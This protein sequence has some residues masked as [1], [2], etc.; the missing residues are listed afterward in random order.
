M[1][2]LSTVT[3]PMVA[4][5]GPR[6]KAWLRAQLYL[7]PVVFQ[8]RSG[9]LMIT[10]TKKS[11]AGKYICVGTN[12]VGERESEIAELTVLGNTCAF[13]ILCHHIL[14]FT[15]D[16]SDCQSN[17]SIVLI[18]VGRTQCD[19][20]VVFF[21]GMKVQC[22]IDCIDYP[23]LQYARFLEKVY[24]LNI[25]QHFPMPPFNNLFATHQ[26]PAY[27]PSPNSF[28]LNSTLITIMDDLG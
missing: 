7:I 8:I 10:N 3:L 4:P 24:Q 28:H 20:L 13:F 25:F 27:F 1:I 6:H 17:Y 21:F 11:D 15:L 26:F 5:A 16:M 9:K 14:H 18:Q 12:M 23:T 19:F 2:L 22:M